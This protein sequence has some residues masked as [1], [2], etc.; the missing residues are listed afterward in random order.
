MGAGSAVP[1]QRFLIGLGT[2]NAAQ[3]AVAA[4]QFGWVIWLANALGPREFGV[5]GTV[6]AF[7]AVLN[8]LLDFGMEIVVVRDVARDRSQAPRYFRGILAW[9][10]IFT[11][12]V[13]LCL[14]GGAWIVGLAP[15]LVP[16]VALYYVFTAVGNMSSAGVVLL[17][18]LERFPT[19]ALISGLQAAGLVVL[20]G[21]GLGLGHGLPGV[22]LGFIAASTITLTVVLRAVRRA[23]PAGPAGIDRG[24]MR[25]LLREATPLGL[26]A[27]FSTVQAR[28]DRLIIARFTTVT[29]VGWYTVSYT[30]V[31][32]LIDMSWSV[33]NKVFFPVL[34]RI[35]AKG[36]QGVLQATELTAVAFVALF[37][38]VGAAG[39]QL[40]P[41]L[42]RLL[43]RD[44][45]FAPIAD[46]LRVL[47][48][49]P[50][51]VVL[52]AVYRNVLLVEGRQAIYAVITGASMVLNIGLN[53]WWV[54]IHG[55]KGAA[56]AALIAQSLGVVSTYGALHLRHGLILPV[57]GLAKVAVAATAA[58]LVL[59][60]M[61]EHT[62]AVIMA[63]LVFCG[64]SA[65]LVAL[66][67]IP[68][69]ARSGLH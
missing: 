6:V 62:W 51:P 26:V 21:L 1:G 47:V 37:L 64:Y 61:R 11:G 24:F 20:G 69:W 52:W 16:L 58:F 10:G 53:M 41:A 8:G 34:N 5:Y 30:I 13:A 7:V 3:I 44:P 40:A 43:F 28:L 19:L 68:T 50:L 55:W 66:G 35:H 25:Y 39:M 15:E 2:Y 54:P 65:L 32:G 48:W 63:P 59:G 38:F 12:V 57:R 9:H 49:L 60:V 31:Q 67:V 4:V 33:F 14:V 23:L 42:V 29:A 45:G 22:F 27:V 36:T 17:Q 56:Y 46:V 18:G